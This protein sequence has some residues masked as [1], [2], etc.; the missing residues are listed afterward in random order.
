MYYCEGLD[1]ANITNKS[2]CLSVEGNRW[3]VHR[4]NFDNLGQALMSLFVLAS[5]DGWISLM[6]QGIDAVGVDLQVSSNERAH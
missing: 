2:D 5:K 4:Y 3:V 6:Y 1:V